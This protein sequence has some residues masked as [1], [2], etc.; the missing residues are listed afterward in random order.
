[1][2]ASSLSVETKPEP[3]AFIDL[4][5]QQ[6]RIRPQ[7]DRAIKAVLDNGTYIMGPEVGRLEK[8]LATFCGAKHAIAC[9]SGTDALLMALMAK[10]I[11]PGDAVICPAFTYTAT[12]E[13]IALLGATGVFVDVREDTFNIDPARLEGAITAAKSR[14]LTPKAII[15]VDLFGQPADYDA[16]LPFAEKHGLFV[17]CDAAQAFGASTASKRVGQIGDV[18]ATSFFPAK[19]LGCYG[20]GGAIFTD[21]DELAN[22]MRSILLHGK[23]ADK[24]DVVRVGINGRLDTIQAAVLIEKLKIFADEIKQRNAVAARYTQA[25]AGFTAVPAVSN[26]STSVWAQY[27]LRVD[28]SRRDAIQK[29]MA[30]QGVPTQVYYPRPLHHQPAYFEHV[31]AD[32]GAP[33]AERLSQE[34]LSLPM[35]PYLTEEQQE[36]VVAAFVQAVGV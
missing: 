29:A 15:P 26:G 30:A 8:D 12:P 6:D 1:M 28:P 31:L 19:P 22:V 16:I 34:V 32:G 10:G 27:T 21:D 35:H 24:Y 23:G 7:I 4:K 18:T 13:T 36:R 2:A 3:I 25:L 9:S 33:V 20:D 17:L 14:G 11:G 5:A